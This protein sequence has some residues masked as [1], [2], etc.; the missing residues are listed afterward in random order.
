MGYMGMTGTDSV[1]VGGEWTLSVRFI[2]RKVLTLQE[3]ESVLI[4]PED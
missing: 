2:V 1:Q 3:T 4:Q